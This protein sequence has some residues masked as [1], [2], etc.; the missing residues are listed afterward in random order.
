[1]RRICEETLLNKLGFSKKFLRNVLYMRRSALGIGILKP[2]I[3]VDAL[4]IKL[5]FGHKRAKTRMSKLIQIS[6]DIMFVEGEH[7]MEVLE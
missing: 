2:K 4:V 6:K 3:I 5:Y 7:N 1:M